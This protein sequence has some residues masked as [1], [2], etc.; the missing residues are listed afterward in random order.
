MSNLSAIYEVLVKV[1]KDTNAVNEFDE[2]AKSST[3]DLDRSLKLLDA[4]INQ[5]AATDVGDTGATLASIMDVRL[6][7]MNLSSLFD[8]LAEHL[9]NVV[10]ATRDSQ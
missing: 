4:A 9:E 3:A 1:T 10:V 7:A 5:L 8:E 6:R 2:M